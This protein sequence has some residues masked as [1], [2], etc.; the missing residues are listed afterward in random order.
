[1]KNNN[2]QKLRRGNKQWKK[3]KKNSNQNKTIKSTRSPYEQ[4][5]NQQSQFLFIG[6]K[7]F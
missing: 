6:P 5:N 2:D 4:C 7:K 3:K 1:M